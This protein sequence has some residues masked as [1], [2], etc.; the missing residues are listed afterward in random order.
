MAKREP[1]KVVHCW[2]SAPEVKYTWEEFLPMLKERLKG[3]VVKIYADMEVRT[4]TEETTE[5]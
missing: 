5:K 1:L 3:K 2:A 4:K